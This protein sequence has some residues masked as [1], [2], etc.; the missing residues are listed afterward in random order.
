MRADN[1]DRPVAP[2]P[3]VGRVEDQHQDDAHITLQEG[4]Q[5]IQ[6]R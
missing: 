2:Q 4:L 3:A 1:E 5:T 6:H